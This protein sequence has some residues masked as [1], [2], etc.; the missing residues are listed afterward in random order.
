[1]SADSAG[2]DVGGGDEG[3][4]ERCGS[5]G[6]AA[7]APDEGATGPD[8]GEV[9]DDDVVAGLGGQVD[10]VAQGGYPSLSGVGDHE[11]LG[12]GPGLHERRGHD[13]VGRAL[14]LVVVGMAPG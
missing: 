8:L 2:Q 4:G 10:Q 11:A 14:D 13:D 12:P 5:G 7:E 1:V 9:E 6:G 3:R